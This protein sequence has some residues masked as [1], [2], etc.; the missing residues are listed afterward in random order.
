MLYH[1]QGIL[2]YFLNIFNVSQTE[3]IMREEWQIV[4][5]LETYMTMTC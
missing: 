3:Y 2:K 4:Q 5:L 1:Q